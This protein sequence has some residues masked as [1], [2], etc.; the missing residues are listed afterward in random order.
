MNNKGGYLMS[1]ETSDF[2]DAMTSLCVVLGIVLTIMS[3]ITIIQVSVKKGVLS[4]VVL[5]SAILVP[6][7]IFLFLRKQG[8]YLSVRD[9]RRVMEVVESGATEIEICLALDWNQVRTRRATRKLVE[10]GWVEI[11]ERA[12]GV[13]YEY[14]PTIERKDGYGEEC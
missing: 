3:I 12:G 13:F 11:N 2:E 4:G 5:T 9:L 1:S 7:V 14:R 8:L 10:R 6:L